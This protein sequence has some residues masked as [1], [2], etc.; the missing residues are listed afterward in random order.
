MKKLEIHIHVHIN[1]SESLAIL[2]EIRSSLK[3]GEYVMA[4]SPEMQAFVDASTAAF[5]SAGASL[6]NISADV[7]RLLA[8]GTG[9]SED[10]KSALVAVTDQ[11]NNLSTSLA[12]AAAVVP[13]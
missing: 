7:Q 9:L 10:D 4:L 5:T 6:A 11:L 2:K 12:E 1:D 8:N 3:K 13:E